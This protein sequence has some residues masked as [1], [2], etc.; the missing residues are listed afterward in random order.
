MTIALEDLNFDFIVK[1]F[2]AYPTFQNYEKV[3]FHMSWVYI[4]TYTDPNG[5]VY[6]CQS[7]Y[8]TD[9]KTDNIVDFVPFERLTKDIIKGW[10]EKIPNINNIRLSM[11]NNI[12]RQINPPQPEVVF[13][14]P[15]F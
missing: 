6:N 10:I 4:C 12:N 9:I 7:Q 1:K 15:P 2:L 3:V 8:L 14:E 11:L 13:L 5:K